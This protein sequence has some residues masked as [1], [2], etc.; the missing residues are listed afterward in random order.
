MLT[1]LQELDAG[2]RD[3]D[4]PGTRRAAFD[5][6]QSS[7]DQQLRFRPVEQVNAGMEALQTGVDDNDL[8]AAG[9]AASELRATV[10][11]A[12]TSG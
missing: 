10:A 12:S 4:V 7:L 3:R 2:V 1:A 11:R 9:G 6:V 8:A 5:V